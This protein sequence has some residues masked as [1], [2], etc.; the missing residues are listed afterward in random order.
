MYY[1]GKSTAFL[2]NRVIQIQEFC[3][4]IQEV[5]KKLPSTNSSKVYTVER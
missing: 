1:G 3:T 2:V 5:N 4:Q